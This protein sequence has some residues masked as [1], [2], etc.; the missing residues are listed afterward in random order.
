MIWFTARMADSSAY[1]L[2]EPQPAMNR[3]TISIDDTARK[4]RMPMLRSATPIP[5]ANG[6]VAKISMHGM[7]NTIGARL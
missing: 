3:P 7:R 1:L 4:N 6:M 2:F 5:G